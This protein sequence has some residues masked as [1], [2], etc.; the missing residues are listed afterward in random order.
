MPDGS[1][2]GALP[3]LL[4]SIPI[5]LIVCSLIPDGPGII[6]GVAYLTIEDGGTTLVSHNDVVRTGDETP[7]AET[8][9]IQPR[10]KRI[11]SRLTRLARELRDID[12]I[13][14]AKTQH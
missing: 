14:S 2:D 1:A 9:I 10:S 8:M 4:E 5:L 11:E 6:G 13:P 12:T 3:K 7:P